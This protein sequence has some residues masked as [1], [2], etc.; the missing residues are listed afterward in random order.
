MLRLHR[1]TDHSIEA[2]ERLCH[3]IPNDKFIILRAGVTCGFLV[4]LTN[5]VLDLFPERSQLLWQYLILDL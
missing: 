4:L 3:I 2:T 1:I 5:F